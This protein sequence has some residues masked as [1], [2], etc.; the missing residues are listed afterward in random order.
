MD[1]QWGGR[2]ILPT[3]VAHQNPLCGFVKPQKLRDC[4]FS[5][6]S[7]AQTFREYK[8]SSS[9]SSSS[10]VQGYCATEKQENVLTLNLDLSLVLS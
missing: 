10:R 6:W 8:S 3:L 7:E 9:S 1:W 5:V 2:V 4:G